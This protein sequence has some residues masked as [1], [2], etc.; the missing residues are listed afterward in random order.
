MYQCKYKINNLRREINCQAA[1]AV[2]T[3]T[4]CIRMTTPLSHS[5]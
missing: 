5:P 1:R 4:Y 3:A 2:Q